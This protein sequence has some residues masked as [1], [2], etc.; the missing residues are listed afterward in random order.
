MPVVRDDDQLY[1][2]LLAFCRAEMDRTVAGQ[3]STIGKNFAIEKEHALALPAWGF[4]PCL[5][6]PAV[7]DK[8]QT[9]RVD[10]VR[11]SVPRACA[12]GT[13]TVKVYAQKIQVVHRGQIVATHRRLS[14]PN[15]SHLDPLHYL[16]V[17]L[18]K[19]ATLDHSDVFASWELP[20]IFEE[21]RQDL[22][23]I[24]GPRTGTRQY[25]RVLQLLMRHPVQRIEK[26]IRVC[27]SSSSLTAPIIIAKAESLAA[28]D[29]SGQVAPAL[30]GSGGCLIPCVQ[31]PPPDLRRFDLLLSLSSNGPGAQGDDVYVGDANR[32]QEDAAVPQPQGAQDAHDAGRVRQTVA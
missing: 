28:A 20:P 26:A 27:R 6:R 14:K 9:V 1:A 15:A 32:S 24:H 16:P 3:V 12:F 22:E 17:L 8:Y 7:V 18:R 29:S 25:I 5:S 30:E 4:D 13:V 19:P 31:V 21:L 10:G 23:R 11:Y 2:A